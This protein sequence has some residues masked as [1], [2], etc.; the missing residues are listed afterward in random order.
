MI[1]TNAIYTIFAGMTLF[2]AWAKL[3]IFMNGICVFAPDEFFKYT[4]S[5]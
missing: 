5:E 3:H 2:S 1:Y 4:L